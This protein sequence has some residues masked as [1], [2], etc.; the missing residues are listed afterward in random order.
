M[1]KKIV[2]TIILGILLTSIVSAT[3][4][5]I[6]QGKQGEPIILT[7]I[8]DDCSYVNLT[9]VVRRGEN[10]TTLLS[11]EFAM[12]KIGNNYNYSFS[13]T[14]IIGEYV[15]TTCGDLSGIRTCQPVSFQINPTGFSLETSESMIYIIVI[16]ATFILFL[17]MLYPAIK[18]P[19]SNKVNKDGSIT[20]IS[21]TKYLKL[22]S[23]WF[24]YGFL[25][26]FLQT[27]NAI[28]KSF[29]ELT[30]LSNF[31]TNIFTYSQAFSVGVTFLILTIIF[32]ELWKDILLSKTIK[33][34]GKAFTDGRLQ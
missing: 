23:S 26:W 17:A 3:I 28:S 22:I 34:Y 20:R 21:K 29:L 1:N 16:I 30:Y 14:N 7:Q 10:S 13:D 31:I 2:L 33:K 9:E 12:T 15:Y 18:L 5:N 11:G 25:M 32:V 6:G 27:L 24:A 19:Y 8:C 4:Y